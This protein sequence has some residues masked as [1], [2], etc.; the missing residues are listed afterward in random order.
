MIQGT[1]SGVGKSIISIGICRILKRKGF[2]V[3]PFKSQNMSSNSYRLGNGLEMAK[4]QAIAAWACEIEPDADMNPILLKPVGGAAEVIVQ[5]K[6]FGVMDR[7]EYEEY[8]LCGAMFPVL[9]SYHR[10]ARRHD[11]IVLEG[12]GSPVELNM[13]D[14]DIA[15]MIMATKIGAPV[16]LVADIDRGGVFASVL[17]TLVLFNPHEKNLVKGIIVNKCRGQLESFNS[18]RNLL[19][20]NTGIDVLGMVPYLDIE[21]EDEDLLCDSR[22]GLK[23]ETPG[24]TNALRMHQFDVLADS[25]EQHLDVQKIIEMVSW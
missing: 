13:K 1:A 16:I 18:V 23:T 8:K 15:N 21:I 25:L 9:E 17:G 3:A 24:I 14:S 11:I 20:H 10:I 19:E 7:N 5:G 6:S 22:T 4:T 12:A 2:D